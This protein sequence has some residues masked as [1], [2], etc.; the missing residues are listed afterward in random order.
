MGDGPTKLFDRRI[1][2]ENEIIEKNELKY[3]GW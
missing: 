3:G 1:S 2:P